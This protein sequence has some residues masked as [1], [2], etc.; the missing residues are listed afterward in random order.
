MDS[1]VIP[2]EGVDHRRSISGDEIGMALSPMNPNN[3]KKQTAGVELREIVC[4]SDFE[5]QQQIHLDPPLLS[6]VVRREDTNVN[7]GTLEEATDVS[8]EHLQKFGRIK[9]STLNVLSG[10]SDDMTKG[11][12]QI[13][14]KMMLHFN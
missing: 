3:R 8:D 5:G 13:E 2:S 14:W 9:S 1:V 7:S 4:Q 6:P 11:C 10:L 12:T